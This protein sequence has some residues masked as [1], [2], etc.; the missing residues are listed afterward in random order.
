MYIT[1]VYAK[2][3]LDSLKILSKPSSFASWS[4]LAVCTATLFYFALVILG[5]F[6]LVVHPTKPLSPI[7]QPHMS[8]F[9]VPKYPV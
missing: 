4:S 7:D 3:H 5:L 6:L 8:I 2:I 1:H 9:G